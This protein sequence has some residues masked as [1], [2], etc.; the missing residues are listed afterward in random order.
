MPRV[1]A[2]S[3]SI[4]FGAVRVGVSGWRYAPWRGAFYPQGL[5]QADE[6]VHA[7]RQLPTLEI[8]GSFYSLQRPSSWAAWHAQTPE[9]FV[10][11]VKAPRFITHV[12]RLRDIDAPLANFLASGVLRL[13]EKLGPMLWQF[14]PDFTF[15]PADFEPFLASLPRDTAQAVA[16]AQRHDQRV[17]G[18]RAWLAIDRPRTLRHAVE[19]RHPSFVDA[20]F[21]RLLRQYGVA[22]VVADTAG[23]YPEYDE[24]T[25]DFVYVR[26]HGS[27]E[28]YRSRYGDDEL[29]RWAARITGWRKGGL[30]AEVR[31][32]AGALPPKR[33]CRDVYVYFDNTDKRHAPDDARRL[34]ERLG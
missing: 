6:L 3:A 20:D 15:D 29:D 26:L 12:K 21:I 9:G 5:R 11:A 27:G 4:P 14:P 22:W 2:R 32:I 24:V 23:R 17:S 34:I 25:A 16:L 28:L 13:N 19:V 31:R 8:N 33:V 18:E 7:S 1:P 30:A 10:F